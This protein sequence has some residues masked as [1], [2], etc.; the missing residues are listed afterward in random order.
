MLERHFVEPAVSTF[1]EAQ[2]FSAIGGHLTCKVSVGQRELLFHSKFQPLEEAARNVAGQLSLVEGPIEMYVVIGFGCAHH[3]RVV[4]ETAAADSRI[5][6]LETNVAFFHEALRHGDFSDVLADPRVHVTVSGQLVKIGACFAAW[7]EQAFAMVIHEPSLAIVPAALDQ[8]REL[9]DT[10]KTHQRSMMMMR[11]LLHENFAKNMEQSSAGI[12]A[13]RNVL[14]GLPVVLIGAGPSLEQQY[15]T[16]RDV[17]KHALIAAVGRTLR[18]LDEHQIDPDLVIMTDPQHFSRAFIRDCPHERYPL[19]YLCTA[20]FQIP[21][22]YHGTKY[23]IYQRGFLAA[24]EQAQRE[25]EPLLETGGSVATTLLDLLLYMGAGPICTIGLDLAFTNNR[26]H[27]GGTVWQISVQG[28]TIV[29]E[30]PDFWR[31]A[32]VRTSKTFNVFREWFT[33]RAVRLNEPGRLL[34][35][36]EGGSYIE[37]FEHIE[38]REFLRRVEHVDIE[39]ERNRWLRLVQGERLT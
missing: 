20:S 24:E 7:R 23:K 11:E 15:E 16:L 14:H 26:S 17:R 38:F 4:M 8:F 12:G 29:H 5:E 25:G 39:P 30:V 28:Q 9:L 22:R 33:A 3:I 37:G 19:F 27:A 18:V 21:Q 10:F 1:S 13:F 2:F 6:I 31:R 35:A 34:N 36:S 32:N